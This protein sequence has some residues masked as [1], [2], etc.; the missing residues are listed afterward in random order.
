[1]QL[2][3]TACSIFISFLV[4]I[5]ELEAFCSISRCLIQ[6]LKKPCIPAPTKPE[7]PVVILIRL[8]REQGAVRCPLEL[9]EHLWVLPS[10]KGERW[11]RGGGRTQVLCR[12][13][14]CTAVQRDPWIYHA[15][16]LP[17]TQPS[18]QETW[19]PPIA[20]TGLL[21]PPAPLSPLPQLAGSLC[22]RR[23]LQDWQTSP[24]WPPRSRAGFALASLL[25]HSSIYRAVVEGEGC[26]WWCCGIFAVGI[27]YVRCGSVKL[28]CFSQWLFVICD[29]CVAAL[30]KTSHS[31]WTGN[32]H[33]LWKGSGFT[34]LIPW[35][36]TSNIHTH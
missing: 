13:R 20:G 23:S 28:S 36:H 10:S 19:F 4:V 3:V 32:R 33:F 21:A 34:I 30:R 22:S 11:E 12:A 24:R 29:V 31:S 35:I 25:H 17:A 16:T 2:L 8:Q 1:M 15:A 18:S 14:V 6:V 5:P 27:L 7:S 9:C 26:H